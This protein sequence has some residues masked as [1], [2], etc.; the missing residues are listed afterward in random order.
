MSNKI[1]N[2]Y[3]R[4]FKYNDVIPVYTGATTENSGVTGLVPAAS[5][6]NKDKFLKGDGTWESV[7]T[8]LPTATN[9][10]KGGVIIGDNITVN[11]GTISLTSSNVTTALGYT[12]VSES[13]RNKLNIRSISTAPETIQN[14]DFLICT[15]SMTIT[16]PVTE[17][18]SVHIKRKF[19]TGTL[20]ITCTGLIEGESSVTLEDGDGLHLYCDGTTYYII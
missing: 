20:T 14:N 4:L 13:D 18:M 12:P 19:V 15:A 7:Q 16:L 11:N 1:E 9:S 2:A 8:E 6:A 5:S 17:H 3:W 10:D